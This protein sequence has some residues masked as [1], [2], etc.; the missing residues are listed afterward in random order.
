[1]LL[2]GRIRVL[3]SS[4]AKNGSKVDIE[5]AIHKMES[6][7][8][9]KCISNKL[10]VIEASQPYQVVHCTSNCIALPNTDCW[11]ITTEELT[12]HHYN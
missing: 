4:S 1:M 8:K 11:F 9:M 6:R 10:N 7:P 5:H 2:R 3:L 12:A